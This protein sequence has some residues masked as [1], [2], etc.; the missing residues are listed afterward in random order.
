MSIVT[1]NP[2]PGANSQSINTRPT[3]LLDAAIRDLV[4]RLVLLAPFGWRIAE[5]FDA[6]AAGQATFYGGLDKIGREEGERDRHV[7]LP[8]AALLAD[9]DFLDC[10]HST[11]DHIVEL[12]AAFCDGADKACAS[13]ELLRLDV[14]PR[15]MMRQQDPA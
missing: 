15:C 8:N 7:D 6:D 14:P 10:G 3:D 1:I 11:I 5:P 9:A 2:S 13:L 4:Q 12:L